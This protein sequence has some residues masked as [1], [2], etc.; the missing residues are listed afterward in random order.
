MNNKILRIATS[1]I[2]YILITAA[3]IF[4]TK[5]GVNA[6]YPDFMRSGIG[7]SSSVATILAAQANVLGILFIWKF[8]KNSF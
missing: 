8:V 2:L 7:W 4:A 3:A 1:V 6:M 5:W